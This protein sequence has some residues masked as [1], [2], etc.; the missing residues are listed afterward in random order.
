[1]N[2]V[3]STF[4]A[5]ITSKRERAMTTFL[6][7]SASLHLYPGNPRGIMQPKG[8]SHWAR[9]KGKEAPQESVVVEGELRTHVKT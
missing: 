3:F 4:D 5:T 9:S 1:M 2:E 8:S 6:V 7:K